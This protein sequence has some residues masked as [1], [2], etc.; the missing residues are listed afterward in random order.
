MRRKD[1]LRHKLPELSEAEELQEMRRKDQLRHK[2]PELSEA[3][4]LQAMRKKLTSKILPRLLELSETEELQ[5]MM[6]KSPSNKLLLLP[7]LIQKPL[8]PSR[9]EDLMMN[10]SCSTDHFYVCH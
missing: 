2:L 10:L 9:P 6:R 4:E 7:R 3:E 8:L 1:Q 5:V